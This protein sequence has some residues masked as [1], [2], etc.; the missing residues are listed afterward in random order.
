MPPAPSTV[1]A[2]YR[3]HTAHHALSDTTRCTDNYAAFYEAALDVARAAERAEARRSLSRQRRLSRQESYRADEEHMI[4]S[5]HSEA[6]ARTS[7]SDD[8][9]RMVQSMGSLVDKRGRSLR[10]DEARDVMS[11]VDEGEVLASLPTMPPQQRSESRSLSLVRG[12]GGRGRARRT[13]G[14]AFMSIGLLVG[15]GHFSGQ[16]STSRSI[17]MVLTR[18]D[19][20]SRGSHHVEMMVDPPHSPASPPLVASTST[21]MGPSVDLPPPPHH[22]SQHEISYQRLVGRISAWTC[23]TLYLTSR[24]P[25]IW[26][27]VS[28]TMM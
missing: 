12:S 10:R 18:P 22:P 17:G 13:A 20:M 2:L 19:L 4:E 9:R 1:K 24:L 28:P 8:P 14:V 11:P 5:F 15:C 26:K 16:S 6:S 27:N 7:G 25:Q 23:T 21:L 3:P